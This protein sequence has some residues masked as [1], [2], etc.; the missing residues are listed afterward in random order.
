MFEIT[1]L[2]T[3]GGHN[4]V[5]DQKK[6]STYDVPRERLA[7]ACNTDFEFGTAL[8][9]LLHEHELIGL[10]PQGQVQKSLQAGQGSKQSC[11]NPLRPKNLFRD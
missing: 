11:R 9:V 5:S 10:L 7:C 2:K 8:A 4:F 3:L 1:A 6:L